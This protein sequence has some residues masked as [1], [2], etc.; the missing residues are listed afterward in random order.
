MF[1]PNVDRQDGHGHDKPLAYR[2]HREQV[3]DILVEL[4]AWGKDY[5]WQN[6]EPGAGA[7][8]VFSKRREFVAELVEIVGAKSRKEMLQ[9]IDAGL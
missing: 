2:G 5:D 3:L 9:S 8:H 7:R 4:C 1:L 6:E